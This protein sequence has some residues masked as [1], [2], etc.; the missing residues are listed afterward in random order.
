MPLYV[1]QGRAVGIKGLLQETLFLI[2][3][4][5]PQQECETFDE[6]F[7]ETADKNLLQK[8]LSIEASGFVCQAGNGH[9]MLGTKVLPRRWMVWDD[10]VR[11]ERKGR[12]SIT[13]VDLAMRHD[14]LK[15]LKDALRQRRLKEVIEF[16]KGISLEPVD[17]LNFLFTDCLKR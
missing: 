6:R 5:L 11:Y 2:D 14:L 8:P 16:I 15:T 10:I 7:R 9:I 3:L 1:F 17:P 4:G 12:D 13:P